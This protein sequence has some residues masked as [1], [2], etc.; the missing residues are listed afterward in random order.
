MAYHIRILLVN[1]HSPADNKRE[2]SEHTGENVPTLYRVSLRGVP[3]S[4]RE[5]LQ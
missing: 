2:Q 3:H 5:V 4:F 1:A